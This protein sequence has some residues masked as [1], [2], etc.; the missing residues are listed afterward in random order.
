[1]NKRMLALLVLAAGS[2]V[3][4]GACNR[5]ANGPAPKPFVTED[6]R[7]AVS[8]ITAGFLSARIGEFS[9]DAFEGR[10]TATPGDVKAR[11]WLVQQMTALGLQPGPHQ[12]ILFPRGLDPGFVLGNSSLA[13]G[14]VGCFET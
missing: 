14:P 7:R 3:L 10:G 12:L 5:K 1:M 11:A 2:A 6:A 8:G 4:L 13:I 9:S